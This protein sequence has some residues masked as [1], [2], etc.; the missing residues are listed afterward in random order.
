MEYES[1]EVGTLRRCNAGE[2]VSRR[3]QTRSGR[4]NESERVVFGM[5]RRE[6]F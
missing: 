1:E 4:V 2:R 3:G 5:I 6:A